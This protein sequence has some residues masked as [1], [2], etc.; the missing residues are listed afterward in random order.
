MVRRSDEL[1]CKEG[2]A[3]GS[4]VTNGADPGEERGIYGK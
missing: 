4:G 3:C 1:N 2:K